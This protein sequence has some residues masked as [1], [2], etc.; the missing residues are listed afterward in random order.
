[1]VK[2][3][4]KIRSIS[5]TQDDLVKF[6]TISSTSV[7]PKNHAIP[8]DKYCPRKSMF[9]QSCFPIITYVEP[10]RYPANPKG[11]CFSK[12]PERDI[13]IGS[14]LNHP[15]I[16]YYKPNLDAV[17]EKNCRTIKFSTDKALNKKYLLHKLWGSY[18]VG[19]EYKIVKL[20]AYVDK[21]EK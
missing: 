9:G 11:I 1:M 19:S 15:P 20:N 16:G 14:S 2:N 5:Q 12:M 13:K 7:I 18:D 3:K 4:H 21:V 17:R 10:K 8:F 6:E